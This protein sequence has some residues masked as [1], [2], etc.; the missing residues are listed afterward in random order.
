MSALIYRPNKKWRFATALLAAAIIHL[1]AVG[2]AT[3]YRDE[4]STASGDWNAPPEIFVEPPA[5]DIDPQPDQTDPL[6]TPPAIDQTYVEDTTPPVRRPDNRS[7][8]LVR[9]R[10]D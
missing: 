5:T 3:T 7:S 2:F 10:S 4:P 6:P 8:P 1:A 9:P